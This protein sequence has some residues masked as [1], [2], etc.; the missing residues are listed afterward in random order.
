MLSLFTFRHA[1][2]GVADRDGH[3]LELVQAINDDGR[4]YLTQTSVDGHVAIR[5]QVGQFDATRDDVMLAY[6][7]I[8]ECAGRLAQ[9]A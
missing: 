5:F 2:Q 1:P 8:T 6:D 7:V 4:I 3:N 9:A